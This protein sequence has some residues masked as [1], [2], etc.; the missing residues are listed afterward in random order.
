[1]SF[2]K[3]GEENE[4]IWQRAIADGTDDCIIDCQL[5]YYVSIIIINH[6]IH[7]KLGLNFELCG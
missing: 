7:G 2:R 4:M 6:S 5:L 3:H 1:M